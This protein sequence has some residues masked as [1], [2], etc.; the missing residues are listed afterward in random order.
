M[1]YCLRLD[2]PFALR[3]WGEE[4]VLFDP[5]SGD[6][7]LLSRTGVD[8]LERLQQGPAT[9]NDIAALF[10]VEPGTADAGVLHAQLQAMLDE[11]LQL[12]LVQ[13]HPC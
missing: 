1:Q 10:A 13:C 2:A 5:A 3:C 8:L 7:H 4:C 6:T 11:F 9:V 12:A